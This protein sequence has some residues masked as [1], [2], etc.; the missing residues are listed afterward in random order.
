MCGLI[1][2]FNTR[3]L[4]GKNLKNKAP[5]L[6]DVNDWL[7]S[8][9]DQQRSRGLEG[10]GF[11]RIDS[12]TK[13]VTID[14]S[15]NEMKFMMDM[16]LKGTNM[17]IAHHRS[18]TS[19]SNEIFQTHPMVV[20][21]EKLHHDYLVVHNG[22]IRNA[23]DLKKKHTE[24]GFGDYT[25]LTTEEHKGYEWEKFN[26]SESLAIELALFI[27]GKQTHLGTDGGAAFIV[28]QTSKDGKATKVFYGRHGAQLNMS[29]SRGKMRLSSEGEGSPVLENEL[30]SF[31]ITDENMTLSSVTLPFI[32]YKHPVEKTVELPA[33]TE[34]ASDGADLEWDGKKHNAEQDAAES[35]FKDK[36]EELRA[37]VKGASL[38]EIEKLADDAVME[39]R[40][41]IDD[42]VEEFCSDCGGIGTWEI[43]ELK[44]IMPA[45][46]M[47]FK[48]IKN[49]YRIAFD[50]VDNYEGE[51]HTE[52]I[53]RLGNRS[54]DWENEMPPDVLVDEDSALHMQGRGDPK[55]IKD[56]SQSI[57]EI[58]DTGDVAKGDTDSIVKGQVKR[59]EIGKKEGKAIKES[60]GIKSPYAIKMGFGAPS[61]D[62]RADEDDI[63]PNLG[64]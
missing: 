16:Y 17:A 49:I 2:A 5:D 14:R 64:C 62:F 24:M 43:A 41:S 63:P 60:M 33:K 32:T 7:I 58:E 51:H 30:Y 6:G 15:I 40:M 23:H 39:I 28:L 37:A 48:S 13:E 44:T 8:T 20:G 1:A 46:A 34:T 12:K 26:D 22:V 19:T 59:G 53:K 25:T 18:P 11:I 4:I 10:F 45:M 47:A 61:D 57:R 38:D 50:E 3:P 31:D 54:I 29:K 21:N 27:E 52:A 55:G 42:S 36:E 56:L 35:F 9:F